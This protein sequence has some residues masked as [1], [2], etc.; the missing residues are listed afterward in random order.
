MNLALAVAA[1][2]IKSAAVN[3]MAESSKAGT[4]LRRFCLECQGGSAQAVQG[5]VDTA[6]PLYPARQCTTH[7]LSPEIRP[8]RLIR[9]YC[10]NCAET[11]QD[12]RACEARTCHLWSL[13][14]GVLPATFKRVV[15]RQRVQRETIL[16][17]G[18]QL[19]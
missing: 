3:S 7:P 15:A 13:R 5:C 19:K 9:Q 8:L 10:L 12:V 6:C 17:P 14:F 18:L 11:R 16:L 1:K 4:Q 2:N